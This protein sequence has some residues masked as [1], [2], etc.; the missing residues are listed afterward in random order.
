MEEMA[1]GTWRRLTNTGQV[2]SIMF[3]GSRYANHCQS[4][5]Q[6]SSRTQA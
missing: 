2:I 5:C 4:D 6:K 3:K 1:A